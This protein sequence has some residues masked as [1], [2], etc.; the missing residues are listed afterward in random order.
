ML[1]RVVE[2]V[3]LPVHVLIRPRGGDFLF[4]GD[5]SEVMLRD[6]S[7]ARTAGARG[8]VIGALD[9]EGRID[10]RLTR[11]LTD[12]ARPLRC[13]DNCDVSRGEHRIERSPSGVAQHVVGEFGT[14]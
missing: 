5:E 10:T 14:S 4:D 2:R 11:R 8:V 3:T 13:P 1:T 7:A 12:A 9:R 6:I